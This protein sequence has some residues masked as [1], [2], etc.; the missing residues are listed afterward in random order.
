MGA[1]GTLIGCLICPNYE[2]HYQESHSYCLLS[3]SFIH[4]LQQL[5][6]ASPLMLGD[7]SGSVFS[8]V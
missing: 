8:L 3:H 7:S 5:L 1:E 4:A 2:P 6:R